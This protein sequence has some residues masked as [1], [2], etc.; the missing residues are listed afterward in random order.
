MENGSY[1]CK[2]TAWPKIQDTFWDKHAVSEHQSLQMLTNLLHPRDGQ[3]HVQVHFL[4]CHF[5]FV[6]K[7]SSIFKEGPVSNWWMSFPQC[8]KSS[9]ADGEMSSALEDQFNGLSCF[10]WLSRSYYP[11]INSSLEC[12]LRVLIC[13]HQ[14]ILLTNWQVCVWKQARS[15]QVGCCGLTG[16]K[17]QLIKFDWCKTG[18]DM[19]QLSFFWPRFIQK[20]QKY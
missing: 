16:F 3:Q 15:C 8:E 13:V 5:G 10:N 12:L 2:N 20:F 9:G 17:C 14:K 1:F 7:P 18:I 6:I 11:T 19:I 4:P